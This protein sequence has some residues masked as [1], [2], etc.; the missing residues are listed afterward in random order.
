MS[1]SNTSS[2]SRRVFIA[3]VVA[4]GTA[5][6]AIG[7]QA[8]AAPMVDE[9]DAQASAL[10]YVADTTKADAK[11]FA[12]HTNEQKCSAC[13]LYTGKAGDKSGP[14]TLFAGKQVTASGWC[15]AFVKKT[16]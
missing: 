16:A 10:G 4:G 7:V 13:Q 8:Q 11:K 15:S 1:F 6:I 3:R 9:K 5:V 14:C 2:S 12:N